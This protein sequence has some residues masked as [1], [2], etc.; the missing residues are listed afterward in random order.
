MVLP[1]HT[2][3]LLAY[4]LGTSFPQHR[5]QPLLKMQLPTRFTLRFSA[6]RWRFG[7]FLDL[8]TNVKGS[9]WKKVSRKSKMMPQELG[10]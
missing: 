9:R 2:T 6:N 1:E 8:S 7:A 5:S 10:L 3:E 4:F